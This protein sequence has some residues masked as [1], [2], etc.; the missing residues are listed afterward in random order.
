MIKLPDNLSFEKAATLPLGLPQQS[1]GPLIIALLS[2]DSAAP[3][4]VPGVTQDIV[5]AA[6]HA[7]IQTYVVAFKYVWIA[8]V[9]LTAVAS[10][11]KCSDVLQ[12]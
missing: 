10:I 2:G 12:E 9:C 8:A 4:K 5:Y 1:L 3:S 11:R 7:L 6:I